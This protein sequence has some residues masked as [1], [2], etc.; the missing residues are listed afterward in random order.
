MTS[1]T[2]GA[3]SKHNGRHP[4]EPRPPQAGYWCSRFARR[5]NVRLI[6]SGNDQI[7]ETSS[8][9]GYRNSDRS[10]TYARLNLTPFDLASPCEDR[11]LTSLKEKLIEIGAKVVSHG[12][13]V[14]FQMAEVAVPRNLF[15]NILRMIAELR[16]QPSPA[17]A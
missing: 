17:P 2:L 8:D 9:L 7:K 5:P 16:P 12:R 11:S 4:P 10:F 6:W 1:D 14:A 15:A 3:G 13:Y